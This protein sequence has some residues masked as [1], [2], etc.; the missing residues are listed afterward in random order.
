MLYAIPIASANFTVQKQKL[1]SQGRIQSED[2]KW[3]CVTSSSSQDNTRRSDFHIYCMI[4]DFHT[5]SFSEKSAL[6]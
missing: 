3:K 1:I 6:S 5:G 4:L 2:L